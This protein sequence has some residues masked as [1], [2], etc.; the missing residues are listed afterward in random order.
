MGKSVVAGYAFGPASSERAD[1]ILHTVKREPLN[2]TITEKGQLESADNRD[3]VCRVR[4]GNKGYATTITWVIDDSTRVRPGQL[5]MVL[6]DSALKDL[7]EAQSITVKEKMALKVKAEKDYEIQIKKN[8]SAIA[9]AETALTLAEIDLD[10]LTGLS[11]DRARM[12]LAALAGIPSS[13]TEGGAYQQELDDLSGQIS[14]AQSEVEQNGERAAW[15]D[16]MVK[17]TYMSP[18]QA[19]AEK[20]RLDSSIEKLRSL[21]SKKSLLISHD[22]RQR[23]TSLT[24]ARDNARRALAEAKLQ[25]EALEIQFR[26]EMQTKT[27]IYDQEE[28]KLDDLQRQ[29]REC[30]IYAPDDIEDGSMVVYFKNESSRSRGSTEGLIEQGAQVKEG[31]K[32]L[33]IPNLSRMQVTTKI[34]EAM[35]GRVKGDVRVPTRL[36]E[37][38]QLGMLL[39][40]DLVGRAAATRPD[41]VERVREHFRRDD[42]QFEYK[43]VADGQR[44]VIR[45]E[46]I[47]G[48]QFAGHVRN[49]AQGASPG[50]WFNSEV[51]LFATSILIDGEL[52]PDGRVIPLV[53]ERLKPDMTAEVSIHV[54]AT[55]GPVLTVPMQAVIG[56]AELR[57]NRE[58]FVKTANGYERKPVTLGLY[59][60]RFVEVRTGL[61]EGDEVVVNPKV[62]LGDDKTRT[63]EPGEAK[64]DPRGGEKGNPKEGLPGGPG[65]PGVAPGGPGGGEP[66]GAP[67]KGG[68]GKGGKGG[69]KGG[70]A[71]PP[72]T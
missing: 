9:L 35:V 6:D 64:G 18:A 34:H 28:A 41:L 31:Q 66:G 68:K 26:I 60:D 43:K 21:Q 53:G 1:V 67:P 63:R 3:I 72:V 25:A 36:A 15:A 22:R 37:A 69:F 49:V 12:P 39:N 5:I 11:P 50:D 23:V 4:A 42:P 62:L 45:V 59:N 8:E 29:R 17:L 30:K 46:S 20:S 13:L 44:A 19:Q 54:E 14:L 55:D 7:E 16:R 70:A 32:M 57:D 65:G 24:S 10:K 58:V 27:S 38:V 33:R 2:V 40:P 48:K 51:K 47:V 52:G 56:G 61:S 71:P